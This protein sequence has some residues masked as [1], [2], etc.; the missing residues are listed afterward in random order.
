MSIQISGG[1]TSVQDIQSSLAAALSVNAPNHIAVTVDMTSATWNTVATHEVFAVTGA[2][3]MRVWIL[4]T[5]TP[6]GDGAIFP[7]D[8]AI[9]WAPEATGLDEISSGQM[10]STQSG[11][12][13][14]R[15]MSVG[16]FDRVVFAVGAGY[17]IDNAPATG[18]TFVFHCVWE[19][20]SDG[21]TV[22]A[23]AGGAL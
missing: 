2:V 7:M 14:S 23:G 22:V 12:S 5:E 6:T 16:V 21:A 13:G 4:C 10:L 15:P 9:S 18:G 17:R 19:P 3:R 8:Q 1:G 20:L 11:A